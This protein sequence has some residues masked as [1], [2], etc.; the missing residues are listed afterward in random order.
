MNASAL[1]VL[2]AIEAEQIDMSIR[3]RPDGLTF[4]LSRSLS[5]ELESL[6]PEEAFTL[7]FEPG[8]PSLRHAVEQALYLH[9]ELTLP[10]RRVSISYT[11]LCSV[12][13]PTDLYRDG[14]A[15]DWLRPIIGNSLL[16]DAY[17]TLTYTLPSEGKVLLSAMPQDLYSY[18]RRTYLQVDFTPYYIPALEVYQRRS[19]EQAGEKLCL[20]VRPDGMD[21]LALRSGEL[22][23]INT[24]S[25]TKQQDHLSVLD[26]LLF[27][28]FSLWRSLGLDTEQDEL[29]LLAAASHLP[30]GLLAQEAQE[31]LSVYIRHCS[32]DYFH[33]I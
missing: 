11:P 6:P 24:F 31:R 13:V 33:F 9:P 28:T 4:A 15:S 22:R 20:I 14:E 12:L 16:G 17:A 19:R 2:D 27:Y 5:N 30:L 23:L 8:H 3:L 7:G 25:W 1:G 10:Y 29:V 18:L 32:I 21:V 26:E